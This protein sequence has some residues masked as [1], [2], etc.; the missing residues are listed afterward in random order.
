MGV[1]GQS[2]QETLYGGTRYKLTASPEVGN[3]EYGVDS[4]LFAVYVCDS[5]GGLTL[6]ASTLW[7]PGN[8]YQEYAL[9]TYNLVVT[10]G[11][12]QVPDGGGVVFR[13]GDVYLY[14]DENHSGEYINNGTY[15]IGLKQENWDNGYWADDGKGGQYYVEQWVTSSYWGDNTPYYNDA[16][17]ITQNFIM[18]EKT[19][20]SKAHI[21]CGLVEYGSVVYASADTYLNSYRQTWNYG[22]SA[23]IFVS[24]DGPVRNNALLKFGNEVLQPYVEAVAL[25]PTYASIDHY[26]LRLYVAS[27]YRGYQSL[28]MRRLLVDWE[29]GTNDSSAGYPN[30][31]YITDVNTPW[32]SSGAMGEGTDI[33]GASGNI[34]F[35]TSDD[36]W[37]YIRDPQLDEDIT[38]WYEGTWDNNGWCIIADTS[39]RAIFSSSNMSA[40]DYRPQLRATYRESWQ[41]HLTYTVSSRSSIVVP[42]VDKEH[43]PPFLLR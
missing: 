18:Y 22:R 2:S 37:N 41:A 10:N 43:Y 8:G 6:V 28:N 39:N 11:P 17:S 4:M 38:S 13:V 7:M 42:Y 29:E 15:S 16:D 26:T 34:A 19:V 24:E 23:I 3:A 31:H 25:S 40:A 9:R 5:S 33:V 32:D 1:Y 21:A 35:I 30:W 20:S 12:V 27:Y 14:S 36:V